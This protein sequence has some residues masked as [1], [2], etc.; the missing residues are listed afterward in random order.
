MQKEHQSGVF[1]PYP[2]GRPFRTSFLKQARRS[3][4]TENHW[5]K[6]LMNRSSLRI[7]FYRRDSKKGE[8]IMATSEH[9]LQSFTGQLV[10]RS[11]PLLQK[12][13]EHPFL[14]A[15]ADGTLPRANFEFYIRQDARYLEDYRKVFA[16]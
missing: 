13:L 3:M 15:L 10:E 16:Y 6:S 14:R 12:Q 4:R 9:P 5:Q 11:V 7:N 8:P 1:K 2:C